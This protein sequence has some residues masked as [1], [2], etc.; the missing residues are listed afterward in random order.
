MKAILGLHVSHDASAC[1]IIDN[2]IRFAVQEERLTRT[3]FYDGFPRKAVQWILDQ[4]VVDPGKLTVAIAGLKQHIENPTWVYLDEAVSAQ[5]LARALGRLAAKAEA[6]LPT[7]ALK[8]TYFSEEV[9]RRYLD[10]ELEA[11]GLK[12]RPRVF[13]DHHECHVAGAYLPSPYDE[14]LI[15]T[16]DGRG[17]ELSATYSLGRGTGWTRSFV[18]TADASLGQIYAGVTGHLGFK[19]LR[20]EGKITGLA[21]FG[22]DT[23]LREK[24]EALFTVADNGAI[25]RVSSA[26]LEAQTGGKVRF[27]A[28]ERK[29]MNV[30]PKE[31]AE[32]THFGITFRYWLVAHAAGMPREDVAYAVQA[33][34]ENLVVKSIGAYAHA[35]GATLP[36]PVGL[37]GGL[38]ANVKLNQRVRELP[39]VSDVFVQPAMGDCGLSVGAALLAA[40]AD[41]TLERKALRHV[42]TGNAYTDDEIEAVLANWPSKPVYRRSDNV[43]DEI[44]QMLA[45]KVIIGRFNG[46]MEFGPRALGNRSII[47]HPGDAEVNKSMNDRL[48]RTEFMPFAP[49]V[50]DRRS[51]DYFI[52]YED[53]Q[54]TTDWMT[55]TYDVFEDKQA[56]IEAVVHI[57]GT[58]R[59]QVVR[60]DTN[61][62]YYKILEAF[63]ARTGI[64]CFV[65]TSFNMHEEPIVAS[66]EDAL[67][68]FDEGSVDVL[69]IGNFLVSPRKD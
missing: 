39:E 52:G 44:G 42:Y 59:P 69:A 26:E 9:Y 8:S 1:L 35:S 60:A 51:A 63:E 22:K 43:E 33:A 67:R 40:Q 61:P 64:G 68:A 6:T 55:I 37:A 49:S 23:A 12:D 32:H 48:R 13:F 2:E 14:A 29:L 15:V 30:A 45:D 21:A 27:D 46:G 7:G 3:K 24:L 11:V 38:F 17:D 56:S 57:D 20:H 36:V 34:T 54:I 50:L 18:Q 47:I 62:S 31:Y 41:G 53:H 19:P 5:P 16:Q 25:T 66:P 10:S 58:A 4:G 28:R 65:N